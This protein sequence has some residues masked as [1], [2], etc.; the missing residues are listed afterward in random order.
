MRSGPLTS[1]SG[2]PSSSGSAPRSASGSGWGSS[3]AGRVG[4][5]AG[6]RGAG[7]RA[8]SPAPAGT[9]CCAVRAPAAAAGALGAVVVARAPGAAP[10]SSPSR[11]CSRSTRRTRPCGALAG[12]GRARRWARRAHQVVAAQAQLQR[13]RGELAAAQ[14]LA[15]QQ[16]QVRRIEA[17]FGQFDGNSV[18][19]R[20]VAAGALVPHGQREAAHAC[21]PRRRPR[22]PA[23][24]A[25][26]WRRPA[27][28]RWCRRGQRVRA[29]LSKVA[30]H[31]SQRAGRGLRRGR[32]R[33]RPA[34]PRRNAAPGR[35]A[36]AR[37]RSARVCSPMPCSASQCS[38][39]GPSSH[40]G[41]ASSSGC[42]AAQAVGHGRR[43]RGHHVGRMPARQ[44]RRALG[45]G[46]GGHLHAVAQRRQ[47]RDQAL[48]QRRQAAE[49]AQAGLHLQQHAGCA[50]CSVTAGVKAR[51]CAP[52]PAAPRVARG[53]GVAET[54]CGARPA[55]WR[56][57]GRAARRGRARGIDAA[58]RCCLDQRQ[59]QRLG[60]RAGS[61]AAKASSDSSGR[62]RA[63]QSMGGLTAAAGGAQ[64]QRSAPHRRTAVER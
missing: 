23:A 62:C 36:A 10:G 61:V 34:E 39:P 21:L 55:P 27:P 57:S 8:R 15:Q 17:G 6:L 47:C 45:G 14:P 54:R 3:H 41:A 16:L 24:P 31:S 52:P 29:G 32:G 2:R 63:I 38:R 20:G 9:A 19:G 35:R 25:A 53:V 18:V 1:C 51:P 64:G 43:A 60:A 28:A 12:W 30:G 22:P 48:P 44:Q 4:A 40:T 59:R 49:Q 56:A 26:R 42:S 13:G 50:S 37:R 7:R 33:V 11:A 5:A 58:M 46:R